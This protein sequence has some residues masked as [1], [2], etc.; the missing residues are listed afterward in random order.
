MTFLSRVCAIYVS[1]FFSSV[2]KQ[3]LEY[4]VKNSALRLGFKRLGLVIALPSSIS[5]QYCKAANFRNRI[6]LSIGMQ[7][8]KI[9]DRT[10]VKVLLFCVPFR[11]VHDHTYTSLRNTTWNFIEHYFTV[12]VCRRLHWFK[13]NISVVIVIS[14]Q[15]IFST[16]WNTRWRV[17]TDMTELWEG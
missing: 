1:V 12:A 5:S 7:V 14:V 11:T 10:H 2:G 15:S 13:F 3:N 17:H 9:F 8:V 4:A 16:R 6:I